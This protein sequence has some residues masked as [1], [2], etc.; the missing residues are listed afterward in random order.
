M[1][2]PTEQKCQRSHLASKASHIFF[3]F[4]FG[5]CKA[6]EHLFK[7]HNKKK[8]LE[9]KLPWGTHKFWVGGF[10]KTT[11]YAIQLKKEQLP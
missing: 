8:V 4:L 10:Y 2:N 9:L 7:T 5:I 6:S 11:Y 3:P 1:F